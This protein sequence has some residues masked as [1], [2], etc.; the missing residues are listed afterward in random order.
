MPGRGYR[1]GMMAHSRRTLCG[2]D[3]LIPVWHAERLAR[4]HPHSRLMLSRDA[5]HDRWFGLMTG[6]R[7]QQ[8][9]HWLGVP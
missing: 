9:L 7:W 6:D 5:D 8:I 4:L 1:L 3:A 2:E